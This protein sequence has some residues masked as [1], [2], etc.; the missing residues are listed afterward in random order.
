MVESTNQV[1]AFNLP[2]TSRELKDPKY[3]ERAIINNVGVC[4]YGKLLN[5]SDLSVF[6]PKMIIGNKHESLLV[7]LDKHIMDLNKKGKACGGLGLA[8]ILA[9]GVSLYYSKSRKRGG[10]V[11]E[12]EI[13]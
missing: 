10:G 7:Y 6:K 2:Q 12:K 8:L 1:L 4:C 3:E 13:S 11:I 5:K 9:H